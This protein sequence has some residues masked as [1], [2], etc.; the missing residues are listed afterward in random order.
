MSLDVKEV[1]PLGVLGFVDG[2]A[3]LAEGGVAVVYDREDHRRV[4][5]IVLASS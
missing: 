3:L 5:A 1:L 2:F 4:R